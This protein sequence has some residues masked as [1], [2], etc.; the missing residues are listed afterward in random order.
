MLDHLWRFLFMFCIW[1]NLV[2]VLGA[3]GP[4]RWNLL[5]VVLF[6]ECLI[7]NR[8]KSYAVNLSVVTRVIKGEE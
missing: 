5:F 6:T 4:Y 2:A 8:I 3:E 7:E 1:I